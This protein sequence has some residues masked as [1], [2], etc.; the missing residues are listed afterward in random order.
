MDG[1]LEPLSVRRRL[2]RCSKEWECNKDMDPTCTL[3]KPEPQTEKEGRTYWAWNGNAPSSQSNRFLSLLLSWYHVG[4]SGWLFVN[5]FA[6]HFHVCGGVWGGGFG[7][8]GFRWVEASQGFSDNW[9]LGDSDRLSL[10]P[11]K[12]QSACGCAT[13]A[14]KRIK[15]EQC[16]R[17]D[18]QSKSVVWDSAV[19]YLWQCYIWF[20]K[21]SIG[22]SVVHIGDS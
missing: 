17:G 21:R 15:T 4:N 5:G 9:F 3:L 1:I 10:L 2:V 22:M 16:F 19:A 6:L 12:S 20:T 18:N 7:G 11:P 13:K 14:T 8:W